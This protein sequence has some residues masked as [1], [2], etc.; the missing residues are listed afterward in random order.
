HLSLCQLTIQP[1]PR[2]ATMVAKQEFEPLDEDCAATLFE[3]T[4]EK[5]ASAGVPAY[6]ISN[7][8][9]HGAESRHNLTYWRYG[10]YL[11]IGPGAHGRVT[12]GA[13]K[14]ATRCHRAPEIWLERVEG[15]ARVGAETERTPLAPEE[16]GREMMLMG[17]RLAEGVDRAR[18]AAEAGC[19]VEDFVAPAAAARL[20]EAGLIESTPSVFR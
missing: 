13:A 7:H 8:A 16:R 2:C 3:L 12:L 14:F 6:E 1:G 17:L 10:D 4:A 19:A 20:A 5:T 11:G 15:A 18:F 9:R